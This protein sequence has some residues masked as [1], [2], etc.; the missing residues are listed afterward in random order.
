MINQKTIITIHNKSTYQVSLKNKPNIAEKDW[1]NAEFVKAQVKNLIY[2]FYC[3]IPYTVCDAFF[4]AVGVNPQMASANI[5]RLI[6][7][8]EK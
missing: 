1:R 8:Y 7:E 4:Q 5:D 6:K 2:F 3:C